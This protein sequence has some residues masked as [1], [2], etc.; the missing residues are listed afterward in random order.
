MSIGDVLAQFGIDEDE[1]ASELARELRAAPSPDASGLTEGQESILREHGG[2]TAS[3]RGRREVGQ[4][5]VLSSSSNLA[6]STRES[7]S[8]EQAARLLRVDAS[9]V[10]HRLRDRALYG[11]RIGA[12]LRLS[13]WQFDQHEPIPGL[14]AVLAAL[15]HDLHPLEVAGFMTSADPDLTVADQP[16]SPRDWLIGGGDVSTVVALA[17]D[18]D[19]W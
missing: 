16:L 18:L 12:G 13:V 10:R 7:L 2:I 3:V 9:R 17:R 8:V 1:F 5:A 14:R 11:F 15:P 19:E 4:A 6:A